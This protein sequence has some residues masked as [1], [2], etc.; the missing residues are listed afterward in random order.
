MGQ[1]AAASARGELEQR[2]PAGL[3]QSH[4]LGYTRCKL[5]AN[6][7]LDMRKTIALLGI[8]A[9]L[10]C[11]GPGAKAQSDKIQPKDRERAKIMLA[12]VHDAIKKNYYD[13]TFHGIDLEARYQKYREQLEKAETLGESFRTIAAFMSGLDDSHTF[14]IP[15]R[16]SYRAEYGYQAQM[17]GDSCYIT[18]VRP[19]TDAVEKLHAGDQIL[20]LDGYGL[21]RKDMW[22][23]EYFLNSL[24]PSPVTNFKLKSPDGAIRTEQ[25]K[26]TYLQ[27][28]HLKDLTLDHGDTDIYNVIFE[29]DKERR[30]M[31]SRYVEQGE[32]MVWKMPAFVLSE[33]EVDRLMGIARKHKSLILDLRDNPGGYVV[34]LNRMLGNV[35]DHDVKLGDRISRK[36]QK[37]LMAKSRG[38][39]AFTGELIVL[40]DSD[41]ASAAELYARVIQLEHRGKVLGDRSSGSVMEARDYDF[42]AGM[43]D[44]AVFYGASVTD[45]DLVMID[46][47]SLEKTGVTPDEVVLPTAEDLAAGRDPVLAR[48]GELVGLKLDPAQAG[49][50]FPFEWLPLS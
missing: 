14:F 23:L 9:V 41:S 16:R 20:S 43:T 34:T 44:I 42:Q 21:K 28:K 50:M 10:L 31:R 40:V 35:F 17:I 30:L 3:A 15:P 46:G 38:G 24:A 49:K 5:H 18:E 29:G 11:F 1:T 22:Q 13:P 12:D 19:G 32:V 37:P 47:K 33:D 4:V 45:A 36:G 7:W 6:E 27:G 8:V 2:N 48:A 25:V 26:T 39:A